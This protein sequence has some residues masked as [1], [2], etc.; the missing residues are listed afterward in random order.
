MHT[1]KPKGSQLQD[2]FV[3]SL[4]LSLLPLSLSTFSNQP[5]HPVSVASPSTSG[6]TVSTDQ[7]PAPDG[8]SRGRLLTIPKRGQKNSEA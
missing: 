7:L 2:L 3:W 6:V 8:D 1:C 5:A 4:V